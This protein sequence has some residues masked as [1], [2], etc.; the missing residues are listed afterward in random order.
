MMDKINRCFAALARQSYGVYIILGVVLSF[1]FVRYVQ[2]DM[3]TPVLKKLMYPGFFIILAHGFLMRSFYGKHELGGK[4]VPLTR[5][6][7]VIKDDYFLEKITSNISA[8]KKTLGYLYVIFSIARTSL[9]GFVLGVAL[10]MFLK[11]GH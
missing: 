2:P 5:Y 3:Q 1:L 7:L 9:H 10:S 11:K 6:G 8:N 4:R